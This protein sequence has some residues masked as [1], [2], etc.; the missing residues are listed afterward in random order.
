MRI[1]CRL[2]LKYVN[3]KEYG[4]EDP[5]VILKSENNLIPRK[6]R[7]FKGFG[8]RIILSA[9]PGGRILEEDERVR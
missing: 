6:A 4:T 5:Q 1:T 8:L 7:K 9:P 2:K 3:C